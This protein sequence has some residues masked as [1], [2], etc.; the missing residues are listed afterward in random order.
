MLY[1]TRYRKL[2]HKKEILVQRRKLG[3]FRLIYHNAGR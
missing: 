1:R 3:E 2:D